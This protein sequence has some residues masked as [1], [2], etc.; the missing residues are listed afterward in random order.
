MINQK[1][2]VERLYYYSTWIDWLSMLEDMT[3]LGGLGVTHVKLEL[4]G[5]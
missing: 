4:G 3:I 5:P 1:G 2:V